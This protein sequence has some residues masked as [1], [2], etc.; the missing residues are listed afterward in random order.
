MNAP[1]QEELTREIEATREQ[2]GDTAEELARRLDV[3]AQAKQKVGRAR[4]GAEARVQQLTG[5]LR[6]GGGSAGAHAKAA[7]SRPQVRAVAAAGVVGAAVVL[8]VRLRR[9]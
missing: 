4:R 5:L 7:A 1:R 3:K 8:V 2:L 6:G 9:N